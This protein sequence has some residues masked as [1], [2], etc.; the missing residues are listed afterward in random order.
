MGKLGKPEKAAHKKISKDDEIDF[1]LEEISPAMYRKKKMEERKRKL[2]PEDGTNKS[3]SCRKKIKLIGDDLVRSEQKI[4]YQK[5]NDIPYDIGSSGK[6]KNQDT[7]EELVEYDVREKLYPYK[8]VQYIEDSSSQH[9]DTAN[10]SDYYP[11]SQASQDTLL[12]MG[13]KRIESVNKMEETRKEKLNTSKKVEEIQY[14]EIEMNYEKEGVNERRREKVK[15]SE[16]VEEICHREVTKE[17][18][19][20]EDIDP[21][22]GKTIFPLPDE[23]NFESDD[24]SEEFEGGIFWK[25]FHR[26]IFNCRDFDEL[27]QLIDETEIPSICLQRK[28]KIGP[29]DQEDQIA[30]FLMLQDI[31]ENLVPVKCK[32]DAALC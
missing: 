26:K 10:D 12:E 15:M 17:N 27:S 4:K 23:L 18:E 19:K 1:P 30:K 16:Y 14:R 31:E 20:E 3:K 32:G 6:K 5:Q 22:T 9:D 7:P 2:P 8:V 11:S 21:M 25:N 28:M 13:I 29:Q 24:E